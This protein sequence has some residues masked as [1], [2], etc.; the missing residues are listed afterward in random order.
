MLLRAERF[1]DLHRVVRH[2]LRASVESY[3]IKDLEQFYAF[4]RKQDMREATASR[5]AIEWAIEFREPVLDSERFAAHLQAVEDYNREDC[6]STEGLR[7][8]L[9]ALRGGLDVLLMRPAP[10][11]GEASDRIEETAEETQRVMDALLAD[12]PVDLEEHDEEQRAQRLLAHL[13]E[14]HRR[15]EKAAWW[16][17]F[18]LRDLPLEDYS[19]ERSAL[20]NLT[21]ISTVGGTAKRPLKRYSFPTQDNDIRSRDDVALPDGSY[22]GIRRGFRSGGANDRYPALRALCGRRR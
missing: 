21:Y 5:R 10:K 12:L 15:E 3:S 9:E 13:L 11:S 2:S 4:T 7:D 16:E 17:Y 22:A 1:I 14:W 19:D 6:E 18:R 20:A 8:W